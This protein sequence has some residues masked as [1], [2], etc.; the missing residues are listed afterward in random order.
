MY[1]RLQKWHGSHNPT[2]EKI[3]VAKSEEAL[4]GCKL[5]EASGEGQGPSRA[6]EPMMM[7]MMMMRLQ[8]YTWNLVAIEPG[9]D[10]GE[11]GYGLRPS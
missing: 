8:K 5:A 11:W 4:S 3:L 7:M 9:P 2:L 6:V 10:L 1:D